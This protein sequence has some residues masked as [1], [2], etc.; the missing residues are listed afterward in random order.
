MI[1]KKILVKIKYHLTELQEKL[2]NYI[3]WKLLNFK[4]NL[5]NDTWY[6]ICPYGI[7]D[8]YLVC[9]LA[10]EFLLKH[11]GKKIVFIIKKNH[12]SIKDLFSNQSREFVVLD[13][14][15]MKALTKHGCFKIG[16]PFIGHPEFLRPDF[17]KILGNNNINLL[18]I[19]K[20]I[21]SLSA[22]CSLSKPQVS[23]NLMNASKEKFLS[24]GLPPNK[25]VILAP[26][27]KSLDTFP[28]QFWAKISEKL[29]KMGWVVC[30]NC[31]QEIVNIIPETIPIN[32][33]LNEAI[34]MVEMAGWVIASRSGLC[35]LI[36]SAN[37]RLSVIYVKQRWYAGTSFTGSSLRLMGLSDKV[38]EYEFD[39]DENMDLMI[40]QILHPS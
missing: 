9:S 21:F 8:I 6:M 27:A 3:D 12:L 38:L 30:I 33:S 39:K 15:N 32:F 36:S 7:G 13:D 5:K 28:F 31:V 40:S 37:C 10:E 4:L 18:S 23:K 17:V 2:Q 14:F 19:Y 20:E 25:T 34:T 22:N 24:L 26:D 35:D 29:N 11:G 1:I 16:H